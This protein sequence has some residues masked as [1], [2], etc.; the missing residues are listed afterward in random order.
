MEVVRKISKKIKLIFLVCFLTILG[1]TFYCNDKEIDDIFP[2]LDKGVGHWKKTSKMVI[3]RDS[4]ASAVLLEDGNVLISGGYGNKQYQETA[5]I[6]Y[7]KENIFRATGA[8]NHKRAG[9]SSFLL[10]DGK[11]VILGGMST[12]KERYTN[13]VEMYIPEENKFVITDTL[14]ERFEYSVLL[15]NGYIVSQKAVYNSITKDY[16]RIDI[17]YA[18][19]STNLIN[20]DNSVYVTKGMVQKNYPYGKLNNIIKPYSGSNFIY[21]NKVEKFDFNDNSYNIVGESIIPKVAVG[22]IRLPNN[23]ILIVGGRVYKKSGSGSDNGVLDY[24]IY[25]HN[26]MPLYKSD[27][28][29]TY[30][31]W[32]DCDQSLEL[33]DTNSNISKIIGQKLKYAFGN[34]SNTDL[35]LLQNRYVFVANGI[36]R[37][38]ELIDTQT[39]INYPVKKMPKPILTSSIPIKIDENTILFIGTHIYKNLPYGYIFRL[40]NIKG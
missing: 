10:K 17:N 34:H 11:V 16:K 19:I 15:D 26:I 1:I 8:L 35:I 13:D 14:P 22:Q 27:F 28:K 2:F 23:K 37:R 38:A 40:D 12:N 36:G 7:P 18:R 21:T 30:W 6:Y 29:K 4:T 25:K 20:V 33:Y 9:H 24:N 5:E 31:W 39:W 32:K 3:P